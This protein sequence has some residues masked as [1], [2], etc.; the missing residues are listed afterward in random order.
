MGLTM[1]EKPSVSMAL[2]MLSDL[3][4]EENS[5]EDI[6]DPWIEIKKIRNRLKTA[7]RGLPD[8][9]TES[10]QT[11]LDSLDD[12]MQTYTEESENE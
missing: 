10:M 12:L 9:V 3:K 11:I 5:E 1:D 6:D 2:G 8:E 7:I 4:K